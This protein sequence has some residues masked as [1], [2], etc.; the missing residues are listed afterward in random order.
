[1]LTFLSFWREIFVKWL[2]TF[3]VSPSSTNEKELVRIPTL[4]V[5][6]NSAIV[7]H[8]PLWIDVDYHSFLSDNH[9]LLL[10]DFL[11]GYTN[12]ITTPNLV[13]AKVIA[14]LTLLYNAI[15]RTWINRVMTQFTPPVCVITDRLFAGLLPS[16]AFTNLLLPKVVNHKAIDK[17][18][19]DLDCE[20]EMFLWETINKKTKIIFYPSLRDFHIQFLNRGFHYNC[21]I[22]SYRV[23]VSPLC[24]FCQQ[25]DKTYSHLFWQCPVTYYPRLVL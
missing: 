13:T 3:F 17:W 14:Q 19:L 5:L 7:T 20:I 11:Q 8:R 21:K 6:F 10:K 24:S 25:S 16:K 1:M 4:P 9:I 18:K 12:I 2:V 23:K 15:P 22:A